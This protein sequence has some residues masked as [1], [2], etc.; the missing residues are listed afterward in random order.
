MSVPLY[1][2]NPELHPNKLQKMLMRCLVRY[3]MVFVYCSPWHEMKHLTLLDVRISELG[4]AKEL[5]LY[6]GVIL[7]VGHDFQ[8][9][10]SYQKS[11]SKITK[12][13]KNH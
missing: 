11:V 3:V 10:L 12:Q 13:N 6:W 7:S 1:H 2:I 9:G 8:I 5:G 4:G